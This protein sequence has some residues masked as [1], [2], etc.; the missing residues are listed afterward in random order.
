MITLLILLSL[1]PGHPIPGARISQVLLP[2]RWV[3]CQRWAMTLVSLNEEDVGEESSWCSGVLLLILLRGRRCR[4]DC[5]LRFSATVQ[6][7]NFLRRVIRV[8]SLVG[9]VDNGVS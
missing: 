1:G 8:H 5:S 4:G 7:I 6:N 2:T 3:H 9:E